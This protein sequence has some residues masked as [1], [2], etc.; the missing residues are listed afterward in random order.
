M[1]TAFWHER[2]ESGQIGFHE[3]EGNALLTTHLDVLG[4]ERGA[5]V[6]VPLCGKTRDIPW[7]LSKGYRVIGAELSEIAVRD[8]FSDI[9]VTPEISAIGDLTLYRADGVDVFVGDVFA[10]DAATLGAVDAV[11]DRAAL[12]ALPDDM[13]ARYAAHIPAITGGVPQLLITFDYDQAVMPG[14]PF[15][16]PPAAVHR[17]FDAGFT[18]TEVSRR[19]V[20]GKLKGQ[21]EAVEILWH[22]VPR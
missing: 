13:R 3:G 21:A 17:F 22:L 2:W 5:R 14:P 12:V 11:Y 10:L 20:E 4:L 8:L 19:P 6:F 7:L 9:D 16:V 18:V 1:D 15:S